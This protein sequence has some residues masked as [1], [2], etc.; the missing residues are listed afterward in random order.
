MAF[1]DEYHPIAAEVRKLPLH[2]RGRN[3]LSVE[4]VGVGVVLPHLLQVFGA[5]DERLGVV[6]VLKHSCQGRSHQRLTEPDNVT[7]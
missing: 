2:A 5:D 4:T 6:V 7:D 3:D 1:V